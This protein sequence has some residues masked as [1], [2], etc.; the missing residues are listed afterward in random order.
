[1]KIRADD[2]ARDA[3]AALKTELRTRFP[4]DVNAYADAKDDFVARVLA[5]GSA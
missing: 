4:D 2:A 1:M 3:Y 5:T